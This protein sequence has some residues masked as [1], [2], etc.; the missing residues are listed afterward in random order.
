MFFRLSTVF[1]ILTKKFFYVRLN[2]GM[3]SIKEVTREYEDFW[4]T[5]DGHADVETVKARI[6]EKSGFIIFDGAKPIGVMAFNRFWDELPFLSLI[7]ILPEY[8]RCGYG[9]EAMSLFEEELKLRGFGALLV[10]TQTDEDAQHFYRSTGYRECGC[11]V[12][13]NQPM[14]MF[15]IKSF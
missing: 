12:L 10:S 11:L 6:S 5:V 4:L 3:I 7:K 14:E 15:F 2:S 8:R 13:E 1:L 9:R